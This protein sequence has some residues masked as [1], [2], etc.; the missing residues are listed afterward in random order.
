M[1]LPSLV[2]VKSMRNEPGRNI[3]SYHVSTFLFP[4]L[5]MFVVFCTNVAVLYHDFAYFFCIA[6]TS[7]SVVVI[8]AAKIFALIS[9]I[10]NANKAKWRKILRGLFMI[11]VVRE[12]LY[13]PA[14]S[15]LRSLNFLFAKRGQYGAEVGV[16]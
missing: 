4:S 8:L 10:R 3:A 1:P 14:S 2:G 15:F 11:L 9:R 6:W 16:Q 12:F 13:R 5:S 7:S